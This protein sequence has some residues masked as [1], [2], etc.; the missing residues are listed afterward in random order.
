MHILA[1]AVGWTK[2]TGL[3]FAS[4]DAGTTNFVGWGEES[5]VYPLSAHAC[6]KEPSNV[7][8]HYLLVM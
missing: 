8:C 7:L 5:P 3:E 6:I 2:G 1:F 4:P